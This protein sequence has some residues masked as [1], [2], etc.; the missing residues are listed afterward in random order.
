MLPEFLLDAC[1]NTLLSLLARV[2]R[3]AVLLLPL[4]TLAT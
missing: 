4:D 3:G 1:V 2:P